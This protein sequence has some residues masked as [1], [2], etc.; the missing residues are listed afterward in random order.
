VHLHGVD[1]EDV[2]GNIQSDDL[3][4]LQ[5]ADELTGFG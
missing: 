2:L 3:T 1:L 5:G 4:A